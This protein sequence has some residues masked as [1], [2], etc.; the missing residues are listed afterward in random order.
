MKKQKIWPYKGIYYY[1]LIMRTYCMIQVLPPQMKKTLYE[2]KPQMKKNHKWRK[3]TNEEKLQMRK[4]L[5]GKTTNEEKPHKWR[6]ILLKKK[7]QMKKK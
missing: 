3:T 2:E 5:R 1:R 4:K 6:N 7:P